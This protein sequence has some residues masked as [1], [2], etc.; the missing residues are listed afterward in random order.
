MFTLQLLI[1]KGSRRQRLIRKMFWSAHCPVSAGTSC[2][3]RAFWER[4]HHQTMTWI[5]WLFI[6]QRSW[7]IQMVMEKKFPDFQG[8]PMCPFQLVRLQSVFMIIFYYLN[9]ETGEILHFHAFSNK[10]C[11][12]STPLGIYIQFSK[13]NAL[14]MMAISTEWLCTYQLN[15]SFAF[16]ILFLSIIHVPRSVSQA[17]TGFSTQFLM[18]NILKSFHKVNEYVI[19]STAGEP[20]RDYK[21]SITRRKM[22]QECIFLMRP[23]D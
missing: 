1:C 3:D 17:C 22:F 7:V 14:F 10:H 4:K 21:E 11:L 6:P 13:T 2:S 5:G 18:K 23:K 9:T 15:C 8:S 12:L 16:F 19:S 20:T